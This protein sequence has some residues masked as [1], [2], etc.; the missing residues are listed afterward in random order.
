MASLL[1]FASAVFG[2]AG[3]VLLTLLLTLFLT[4]ARA[5]EQLNPLIACNFAACLIDD[6]GSCDK[7]GVGALCSEA[8]GCLCN[9]RASC[10]CAS[11]Q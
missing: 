8:I 5:D 11:L 1:R 7:T 2:A 3:V 6:D 9:E 10:A 4:V